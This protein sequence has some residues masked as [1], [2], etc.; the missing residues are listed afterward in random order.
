MT[1]INQ[2]QIRTRLMT[3]LLLS[4]CGLSVCMVGCGGTPTTSDLKE[5]KR[6]YQSDK[7]QLKAT[8]SAVETNEAYQAHLKSGD[9]K[10]F[11]IGAGAATDTVKQHL[12]YPF[13]GREVMKKYLQG[14][15]QITGVKHFEYLSGNR[16][17]LTLTFTGKNIKVTVPKQYRSFVSKKEIANLKTGLKKGEIDVVVT[18]YISAK[19]D[20]LILAPKAYEARLATN[21]GSRKADL[22]K[23]I[24]RKI[25]VRKALPLEGSLKGWRR[26][27]TT[28]H[29]LILMP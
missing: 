16:A 5:L 25:L 19:K 7:S 8:R 10:L 9:G 6:T 2:R 21:I 14:D 24:N 3:A 28:A 13:K 17:R 26:L 12:P 4:L 18:A 11:L 15:F 29:H 27:L 20:A 1:R 22:I 23:G